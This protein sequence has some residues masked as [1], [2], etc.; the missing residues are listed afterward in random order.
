MSSSLTICGTIGEPVQLTATELSQLPEAWQVR[1]LA[2]VVPGREGAAIRLSAL[3]DAF[4]PTEGATH[5][6]LHASRDGFA[7]SL[8]ME[9]V[10]D[11]GLLVYE[12]NA[13]PL[14]AERG[15][16][17]RFLIENAAPCKTA[18]LDACAN[19]K[20]VDRIE[21]SRGPGADTR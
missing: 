19:V 16:P 4:P 6:T 2:T 12:Q 5:I 15:G 7:A 11:V 14:T 17:F 13:A 10:R 20:F 8:P 3:L 9:A 1:D 18:E 21:Y